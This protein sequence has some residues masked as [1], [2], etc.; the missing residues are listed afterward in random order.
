[1]RWLALGEAAEGVE[2]GD[3]DVGGGVVVEQWIEVPKLAFQT[4]LEVQEGQ[5]PMWYPEVAGVLPL[6]QEQRVLHVDW[7]Q[8]CYNWRSIARQLMLRLEL[9]LGR[10]WGPWL[11]F[12]E[13]KMN[14][15]RVLHTYKIELIRKPQKFYLKI[16][17]KCLVTIK[18]IL[19]FGFEILY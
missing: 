1:M 9:E 3:E 17:R 16:K 14:Y 8:A 19:F 2:V 7:Q 18:Q 13:E 4:K 11:I 15:I 6:S 5:M 12:S 10:T